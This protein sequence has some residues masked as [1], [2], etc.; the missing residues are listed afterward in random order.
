MW[1]KIC[2]ITQTYLTMEQFF[3]LVFVFCFFGFFCLYAFSR[4]TPAAYG[5]SQAKGRIRAVAA[6]LR[7][8]HS[9]A[10]IRAVS[11]THT[12]AHGNAGSPTH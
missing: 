6:G 8:S 12:T 11:P 2:T 4:A 10:G 9:N 3:E 7:Q 1:N 5:G